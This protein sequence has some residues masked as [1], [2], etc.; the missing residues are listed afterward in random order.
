MLALFMIQY[1]GVKLLSY[2]IT[3]KN[4]VIWFSEIGIPNFLDINIYLNILK[5]FMFRSVYI[6]RKIK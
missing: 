4:T 3:L 2:M 1:L 5:S 6:Y